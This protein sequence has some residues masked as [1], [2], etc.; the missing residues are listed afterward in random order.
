METLPLMPDRTAPPVLP[1]PGSA[2]SWRRSWTAPSAASAALIFGVVLG[3]QYLT[4]AYASERGLHSDEAAHLLNGVLLRDYVRDGLG[5]DP[6]AFAQTF[7]SHY[8]KIAPLVWPP[9][10]HVMLGVAMLAGWPPGP[11]ALVVLALC[12]TWMAWRLLAIVA[13]FSSRTAAAGAVALLLTT[14][15]VAELTGAVMIDVLVAATAMEAVWWLGRFAHSGRTRDAVIFGVMAALAC[16]AKGN[17]LSVVLAPMTLVALGRADLLRRPGLYVAA[18]V[19]VVLAGPWLG[20]A[21]WLGEPADFGAATPAMMAQR[22]AFYVVYLWNQLGL[23]VALLASVGLGAAMTRRSPLSREHAAMALALVALVG[24]ALLF[25]VVNPHFVSDGRYITLALPPL[26]ALAALGVTTA[27]YALGAP[28]ARR[29][30]LAGAVMVALAAGRVVAS[31]PLEAQPPLGYGVV[32]TFLDDRQTLA[33]HRVLI[34]SNE[35]GEGA[36]VADVAV[37]GL[38]PAP[39]VLRGSKVLATDDW[40]G[41]NFRL[42]YET[43][44]AVLAALEAMHVDYLV[45]DSAPDTHALGYWPLVHTLV[46]T[47]GD[48]IEKIL[49]RPVDA[50]TGPLRPLTLY[51]LKFRAPGPP[52]PVGM[53][54]SP[55]PVF[56]N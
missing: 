26:I 25:H 7:Y 36:G 22:A 28:P 47:R 39:T 49:E 44:E 41:R 16:A 9:L 45:L 21:L 6:V 43:P 29:T 14:P 13:T 20:L 54:P 38:H 4:G 1:P 17:G 55:P 51:R 24:G 53:T 11:T 8:P 37:R 42:R 2:G 50:V 48:R 27:V 35:R 31:P 46:T 10:F 18:A 3:L 23:V 34:V 30:A 52:A 5:Q 33:G 12:T 19:T 40:M 15:S 56:G 32:M